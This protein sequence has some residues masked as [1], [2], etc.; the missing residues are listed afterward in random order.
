M[1]FMLYRVSGEAGREQYKYERRIR[2]DGP[3]GVLA[4]FSR[5]LNPEKRFPLKWHVTSKKLIQFLGGSPTEQAIVYD[6]RPRSAGKI[7]LYRL[8]DV[9]G[10]TYASW[11]PLAM[12]LRVLFADRE[13]ANPFAFKS[14]FI[15]PGTGHS[16]VG[17]FLSIQGGASEGTWKWGKARRDGG[18]FLWSDALEFLSSALKQSI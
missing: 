18:T 9:W 7:S 6:S 15:D 14:M 11:T 16:L 4:A 2:L 5:S 10:F 1:P 8:L 12:R 3:S 17:E 13:E